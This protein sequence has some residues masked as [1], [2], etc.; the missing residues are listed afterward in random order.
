MAGV[1]AL[2]IALRIGRGLRRRR[3][4]MISRSLGRIFGSFSVAVVAVTAASRLGA[5]PAQAGTIPNWTAPA[6]WTPAR[7]GRSHASGKE[8]DLT[9]ALPFV[10]VTPCRIV[11][12]RG[13][14]GAFGGPTLTASAARSFPLPSGPCSGI[15]SGVGAYSLNVTA[16]NTQGAG[17]FLIYPQGGSQPLVST[18]NYV[19]GQTVANAAI[20]PAGTGGGIT[21][22]AGVSGAD[23]IIDIN[24]YYAAAL[25][26]GEQLLVSTSIA[27]DGAI[28]GVNDI[29]IGVFGESSGN[30]G[31]HGHTSRSGGGTSGVAG[32]GDGANYG[33]YGSSGTGAGMFGTSFTG[34]GVEGREG[35][36][37]GAVAPGHTAVFGDSDTGYGVLGGSAQSDGVHGQSSANSFS[38]VAGVH[39]AGGNGILGMSASG[40]GVVGHSTSG[41]GVHGDSSTSDGVQGQTASGSSSGVSGTNTG[42]GIGVRGASTSGIAIEGQSTSGSGVSGNSST[43]T[44]VFG[45]SN[46]SAGQGYGVRGNGTVGVFGTATSAT[47]VGVIG[48]TGESSSSGTRDLSGVSGSAGNGTGVFGGS[49]NGNGVEGGT[50]NVNSSGVFGSNVGGG[51][52]VFGSSTSG[53]GVQGH[54]DSG[55]GV[56]G[57]SPSGDGVQGQTAASASSGVYGN[58]TGGGKGV[59]GVSTTGNGV[60]GATG[61]AL[62][63]FG[64]FSRGNLGATGNKPFVEPHPMDPT[65][66]IRYACLE[67]NEVGTY[68]RGTGHLVQ[69]KATIDIPEDFRIVTDVKGVTV[70]LTPIGKAASLYCVSRSLDGIQIA[71]SEDIDFDY[72]VNGVRKAF[73]DFQT[74]HDNVMFIPLS[75]DAKAFTAGLPTE[76]VR[77]L[78]ANGTLNPDGSI[79]E[80]TVRRLGWDQRPGW[81]RVPPTPAVENNP[82]P[83]SN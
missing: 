80:E 36:G 81:N 83:T 64:V 14:A 41:P 18:L 26:G 5:A 33:V 65:K 44:G 79:N 52:G 67:G 20:V 12:T 48:S 25:N 42:G 63:N 58:N 35:S 74:I 29:G 57:D 53:T 45:V 34:I 15:P 50:R 69:G 61:N 3:T 24:G 72:Q 10:P 4:T 82:A 70:Q 11:D 56:H 54:S 13:A 16:T 39:T 31:V 76:S 43:G 37:S 32:L 75:L 51:N 77:R 30:D 7:G 6:T 73:T 62:N 19:A 21:V 46:G 71:G 22:V 47:G 28:K 60:E 68:F 40:T 8:V 27:G 9:G 49:I 1:K 38:G 78:I 17:F 23:L 55:P 2:F 66:E 59:F